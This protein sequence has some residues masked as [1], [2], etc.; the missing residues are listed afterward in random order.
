[1]KAPPEPG[2]LQE[3]VCVLVQRYRSEQDYYRTI[4]IATPP[5]ATKEK[6][7]ALD[8]YR[9]ALYPYVVRTADNSRQRMQAIMEKAYLQGPIRIRRTDD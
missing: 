3:A 9:Q 5:T 4:L 2:S 7:E 1:L 8:K 6:N